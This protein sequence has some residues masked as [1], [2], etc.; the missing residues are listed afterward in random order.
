MNQ[1]EETITIY[2]NGT[3]VEADSKV[4]YIPFPDPQKEEK[5]K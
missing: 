3:T 1:D 5:K 2:T 4:I